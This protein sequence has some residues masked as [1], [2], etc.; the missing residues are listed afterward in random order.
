M[1]EFVG[2]DAST[3]TSVPAP[4]S[5]Y[6]AGAGATSH[7]VSADSQRALAF[8][9]AQSV[10]TLLHQLGDAVNELISTI[11]QEYDADK[12]NPVC[13]SRACACACV[14]V[15]CHAV[16][17][18]PWEELQHACMMG[19]SQARAPIVHSH[20]LQLEQI[21]RKLDDQL[22]ALQYIESESM[23]AGREAQSL[24][25]QLRNA[26]PLHSV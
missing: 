11:N 20:L 14:C 25:A 10:N 12:D 13:A 8:D 2:L 18:F 7:Y 22:A 19:F 4:S 21:R 5:G 1:D 9:A 16:L 3:A 6:G 26:P 17:A 15:V 23:E 24:E